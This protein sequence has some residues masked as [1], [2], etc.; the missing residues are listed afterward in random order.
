MDLMAAALR[1]LKGSKETFAAEMLWRERPLLLL[2]LPQL[3]SGEGHCHCLTPPIHDVKHIAPRNTALCAARC[4]PALLRK[5]Q[6]SVLVLLCVLCH[7]RSD[8]T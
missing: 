5:R 4:Q 2:L 7:C 8:V 1:T 3:N 6:S